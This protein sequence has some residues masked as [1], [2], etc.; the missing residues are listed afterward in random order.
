MSDKFKLH[1]V[2]LMQHEIEEILSA[3]RLSAHI[4]QNFEQNMSRHER[5]KS[6]A[7]RFYTLL[8]DIEG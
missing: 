6:M 2:G 8:V 4:C 1:N 3:L 5:I 7:N